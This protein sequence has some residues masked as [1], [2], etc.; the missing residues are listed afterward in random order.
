MHAAHLTRLAA[1]APSGH[2]GTAPV[3]A[4]QTRRRRNMHRVAQCSAFSTLTPALG[5]D[6]SCYK[7]AVNGT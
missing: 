1:S 5:A 2:A 6:N 3:P 4:K 7:R